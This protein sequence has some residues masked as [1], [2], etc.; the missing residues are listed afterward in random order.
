MN[1]VYKGRQK[2]KKELIGIVFTAI[3]V[4]VYKLVNKKKHNENKNIDDMIIENE[5]DL[6]EDIDLENE[7]LDNIIIDDE[8][9]NPIMDVSLNT[10][11]EYEEYIRERV[12]ENAEELME[13]IESV[14]SY[15]EVY[16]E[17]GYEHGSNYHDGPYYTESKDDGLGSEIA[18]DLYTDEYIGGDPFD[19]VEDHD[20]DGFPEYNWE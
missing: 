11:E 13:K 16:M 7:N 19:L 5:I 1:G 8:F 18:Y 12:G 20:K 3:G 15:G 14:S 2:I 4:G 6:K 10:R 9:I 17:S